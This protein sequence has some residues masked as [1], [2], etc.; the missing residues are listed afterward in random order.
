SVVSNDHVGKF[1]RT[2]VSTGS[3]YVFV[4]VDISTD[5]RLR[6]DLQRLPKGDILFGEIE[7]KAPAFLVS[8]LAIPK[9]SSAESIEVFPIKSYETDIN[10]IY[11]K[12]GIHSSSTRKSAVRFLRRINGYLNLKPSI[13]GL[14][15]N[16][17]E[18]I[19]DLLD[20]IEQK[21]P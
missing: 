10:V 3:E 6:G 17:N 16:L 2:G 11:D 4:F 21:Q 18:V 8:P 7:D 1:F 13:F 15:A 12:M 5:H 19:S 20:K 9:L 14:G